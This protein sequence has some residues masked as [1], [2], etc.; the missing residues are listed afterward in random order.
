MHADLSPTWDGHE[1][2]TDNEF[3]LRFFESMQYYNLQIAPK[4]IKSVVVKWMVLHNMEA[5]LITEFK[6]VKDWRCSSTMASV[7]SCMMRGMPT[8]RI[9]VVCGS[10]VHDWLLN[11]I[12]SVI[13]D[14]KSDI[15]ELD[16]ETMPKKVIKVDKNEELLNAVI[17]ELDGIIDGF[18]K[19]L[20][21]FDPRTVKFSSV[22]KSHNVKAIHVQAIKDVYASIIAE[23][24]IVLTGN[25]DEQLKEAYS[26]YN[27][28]TIRKLHESYMDLM[29]SCDAIVAEAS[30]PK[31]KKPV[32]KE[33]L[34]EKLKYLNKDDKL[35]LNSIDPTNI[36]G[37]TELYCYDTRTRKLYKFLSAD[38]NGLTVKGTC[39]ENFNPD[40]SI[41]KTLKK[42]NEQLTQFKNSGK[43]ALS[44]FLDDIDTLEIKA[45]GKLTEHQLILKA[46]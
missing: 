10:N 41:G 2:W 44:K 25:I 38:K 9:G 26:C 46:V 16:D 4:D 39:I 22:L 34:V 11:K 5:T 37:A 18:Y 33:K 8:E 23:L 19:N 7:A 17:S 28:K 29:N 35:N 42:P 12:N 43:I 21:A 14:S 1:E 30:A 20:E 40:Q 24:D 31:P 32:S 3:K 13:E 15:N 6:K 36:I 27:K 45:S